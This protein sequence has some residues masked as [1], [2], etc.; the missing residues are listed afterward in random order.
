MSP[1][2]ETLNIHVGKSAV[3]QAI[4]RFVSGLSRPENAGFR[5]Q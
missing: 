1:S 3:A 5:R 2:T 4:A